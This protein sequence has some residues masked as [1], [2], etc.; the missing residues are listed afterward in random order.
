MSAAGCCICTAVKTGSTYGGGG[1]VQEVG[2]IGV[3]CHD[4][5][6]RFRLFYALV[7]GEHRARAHVKR[8]ETDEAWGKR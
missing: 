6:G 1:G 7:I 3:D 2:E 8:V 4:F 5:D